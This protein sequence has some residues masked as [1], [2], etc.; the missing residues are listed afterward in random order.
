MKNSIILLKK[1]CILLTVFLIC[2]SMFYECAGRKP[3]IVISSYSFEYNEENYR[4]RSVSSKNDSI[5]FNELISDKFVAKDYDQDGLIDEIILGKVNITKAQKIYEYAI[6][7]LSTQNKLR[8]VSYK[9]NA[10]KHSNSEY[11]YEIK[12]FYPNNAEPF[13]EFIIINNKLIL[14]TYI[15]ICVDQKADGN[16]DRIV[17]GA[18]SLEKIQT[19]YSGVI[20]Q[21][22][23]NNALIEIDSMILVNKK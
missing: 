10:Y 8:E 20:Q 4:I 9:F 13:N 2:T 17:K 12:S 6:N 23:K 18:I 19:I 11:N 1:S 14:N 5:F 15:A 16:L 21:G 7:K 3:N 22:L